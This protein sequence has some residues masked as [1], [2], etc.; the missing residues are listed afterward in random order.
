MSVAELN[1]NRVQ[2]LDFARG[3]S[4]FLVVMFHVSIA[5]EP[6]ECVHRYYWELNN[7]LAPIRMPVFFAVSGLLSRKA[8]DM[9]WAGV[10]DKRVLGFIYIFLLWSAIALLFREKPAAG[11]GQY[12]SDLFEST[13]NP[14]SVL[15]FIWALAIYNVIA[16]IGK[17]ASQD[18]FLVAAVVVSVISYSEVVVFEN[19]VHNNLLR[20]LPFFL[21]GVYRPEWFTRLSGLAYSRLLPV[22]CVIFVLGF[23]VLREGVLPPV[24][25]NVA[26]FLQ[27][28]LGV[29]VGA[30]VSA[31]AC[32]FRALKV[33]PSFLGRH[34]LPI[35][36]A[37]SLLISLLLWI[38]AGSAIQ[39]HGVELWAVPVTAL[40][41]IALSILLERF[42]SRVG[43]G[44]IYNRPVWLSTGGLRSAVRASSA[45]GKP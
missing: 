33:V 37:H 5:C 28:V 9:S 16:K 43:L 10:L 26:A 6:Y 13:Y 7:F 25:Q 4:I 17:G 35:Y 41:A 20:Y 44:W 23:M 31:W 45:R 18:M 38:F 42:L 8:L 34:T 14:S 36:V 22:L 19:Y 12:I 1:S 24:L 15:W 39:T 29:A 2:W 27:A 40:A 3:A 21:L 30:G 32:R 11:I